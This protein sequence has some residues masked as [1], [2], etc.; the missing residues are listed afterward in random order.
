[1]RKLTTLFVS[2]MMILLFTVACSS[3]D[4]NNNNASSSDNT[5]ANTENTET[6]S[7][8]ITI[9]GWGGG[10]ELQARKDATDVFR[11][12][13]PD[14]KVNEIWLP[15]DSVDQKL[16]AALAAGDAAD[17]IMMSP[18]WKGLRS[19]WLEDLTPYLERDNIDP[20]EVFTPGADEG[21]VTP[22]GV[23][24]G[25]PTT[26]STFMIAYNKNI[27][28]DAGVPYPTED[29]TWDDFA[30]IAKQL[31]SGSGADRTYGMVR[32]WI[33]NRFAPFF[34]GGK[35]YNE[36]WTQQHIDDPE[37]IKG[38]ELIEDLIKAEAL[39]DDAASE[40][41]PMD[42]MFV[43]QKA[44]MYPLG[45][46][47]AADLAEKIGDNFEW[48]VVLPPKDP[49]GK[50]VNIKFQTGFAMN[51]D[52]ENKEA[53]WAYIKTVSMNKEVNDLYAKVG[54]PA[55]KESADTTF[56]EMTIPNTDIKQ[57]EYLRGLEDA[58]MAPWGGAINKATDIFEQLTE[59]ITTQ[60]STAKE[61]VEKYAPLI[62][63]ALDEVHQ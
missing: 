43:S 52:S 23:R 45:L 5:D 12:L 34:Y 39:P 7:G 13:Y 57:V 10:N 37:T 32:H 61:A 19:Q 55:L 59:E 27:F 49:N 46:F 25:L 62:Q 18:D 6:I 44:A 48:G 41:M 51:K 50:N 38:L 15:A 1:M 54:I 30:E 31:S 29:W 16:D 28:D 63:E 60:K 21:Y 24:E 26:Q 20:E 36:D 58:E 3:D 42:A 47:E 17:V 33:Q 35:P 14:V 56:A 4:G 40:S 8:E 53:A 11:E 2:I 22:D 9:M